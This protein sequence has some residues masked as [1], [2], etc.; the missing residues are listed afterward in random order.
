M[1]DTKA[2]GENAAADVADVDIFRGVKG[3]AN[4]KFAFSQVKTW[5]KAWIVKADVGLGNVDNTADASKPVSTA[6]SAAI[7]AAIGALT[8]TDVG[9]NLVDNTSDATKNNAAGSLAN[10]TLDNS[11]T[12]TLLDSN[13]TL[14]DSN[15]ATKQ[16]VLELS[17]LTA[18][19]KR[20]L[21]VPDASGKLVLEDTSQWTAYTP[22]LASG[23]GSLASTSTTASATGRYKRTGQKIDCQMT[24]TVT[25]KGTASGQMQVGLPAHSSAWYFVGCAYNTGNNKSGAVTSVADSL[26][27]VTSNADGTTWWADGA[28]IAMSITYEVGVGS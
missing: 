16:V 2:S 22:T 19:N 18:S 11:C 5:I 6:Q 27:T 26:I 7:S 13:F 8:K 3:G 10:K 28:S 4:V 9:L 15:D 12:V 14:Q 20:T 17:G 23:A 21:T 25:T 1:A 24:V